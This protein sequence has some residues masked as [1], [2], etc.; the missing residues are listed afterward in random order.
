MKHGEPCTRDES[1]ASAGCEPASIAQLSTTHALRL[2]I[3]LSIAAFT[4]VGLLIAQ[5]LPAHACSCVIRTREEHIEKSVRIFRGSVAELG[6]VSGNEFATDMA[7]FDV[8]TVWKGGPDTS[9]RVFFSGYL[10][11]YCGFPFEVGEDYLVFVT[12]LRERDGSEW[13]YTSWCSLTDIYSEEGEA[14]LGPG[15]AVGATPEPRPTRP[16]CPAPINTATPSPTKIVPDGRFVTYLPLALK[17][18]NGAGFVSLA[19]PQ[20]LETPNCTTP[21]PT[22]GVA[23]TP[24]YDVPPVAYLQEGRARGSSGIGSYC[25]WVDEDSCFEAPGIATTRGAKGTRSPSE[26]DLILGPDIRP[27]AIAM[28]IGAISD[29]DEVL[30]PGSPYRYWSPKVMRDYFVPRERNPRVVVEWDPGMYLLLLRVQW[31]KEGDPGGLGWVEYG[32][33]VEVLPPDERL[34]LSAPSLGLRSLMTLWRGRRVF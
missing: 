25:W 27:E 16:V 21:T 12:T 22:P 7:L 6:A 14:E 1:N 15:I 29:A 32:W 4:A 26:F 3:M 31:G 33:R 34:R 30:V 23:P 13:P 10:G 28:S 19:L 11:P 9:V 18:A 20:A 8:S 5:T 24:H 2:P 17:P